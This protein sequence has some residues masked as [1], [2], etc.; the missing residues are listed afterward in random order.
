MLAMRMVGHFAPSAK[1]TAAKPKTNFGSSTYKTLIRAVKLTVIIMLFGLLQVSARTSAQTRISLKLRGATL[2]KVFAEIEKRSGYTVFYNTEVLQAAGT[3]LVSIDIKDATIDDVMHQCL[4]GLPL[5]FTV[6]DKTIFVKKEA[7]RVAIETVSGPGSP[8]PST[9][10]GIVR[11][12][13]GA[14]LAGASVYVL[15]LKKSL[16]TNKDGEF[17]LKDIPDGE[18]EV[19]ISYIGYENYRTKVSV[20]NHEAWLSAD[21]KQS[22]SKLDETVVKGY[23]STTNRLNTGDVTT[24]KGEDIEKQPISDPIL[25]LEGRVSGL[26]IVQTSGIAGAYSAITIR[27]QNSIANGNDPLYIVDGVPFNSVTLTSSFYG[28]G[29]LGTPNGVSNVTGG[30]SAIGKGMS[31][32]NSLNPSDIESIEVLKDADAT[33]IYG[34]RGANGVILITTKKGKAGSTRFDANVFTGDGKVTRMMHLLN[35]QQYMSMM[36]EAYNNDGL[37]FPNIQ[38]NPYDYNFDIDGVW[39]TT[40]YTNWQKILIGGTAHFTNAQAS[41]S[42]GSGNTQFVLGGGYS[43]QGVVYPGSYADQKAAAHV[44]LTHASNNRKFHVQFSGSYVNDN[45][46]LPQ[47][48]FTSQ[49][50]YAPDAP[51]LYDSKGN[52]NWAMYNGAGTFSNPLAQTLQSAKATTDNLI[53][54]LNVGYQILPGLELRSSFGYNHEQMNQSI[55]SPASAYSPPYNTNSAFRSN[56]VA[57]TDIKTWIIEPQINYQKKLAEGTLRVLIGSTFQENKTYSIAYGANTFASDALIT[58][59]A[60]GSVQ[61]V[62]GVSNV[63]YRYNAA[64]GRVSYDWREKYLINITAR[65]DGSSNFGPGKQFGN[66]GAIGAG[67]I[68]SKERFMED[69]LPFISFGKLRGSYGTTGNDQVPSYQFLSTYSVNASSYEGINTLTPTQLTNTNFAWEVVKKIEGGLD[70]GFCGDRVL[71]S[72]AY[73]RNRTGNQLVGYPLPYIS[74]FS[75]VQYN[76][77]AVVQNSGLEF[78]L[79]TVNVKTKD[80]SWLMSG[81]LSIPRNK[82]VAYPGIASSPYKYRY[83][84]EKSLFIKEV[85]HYTMV[86]PQTGLYT[87]ATKNANG[88]PTSPQD[89]VASQP[90]TQS[91]YGG[92]ENSFTYKGIR[93]DFLFQFVKQVGYTYE[94]YFYP[95]GSFNTNEPTGVLSRWQSTGDITGVQRFGTTNTTNNRYKWF[96]GSDEVIKDASFIRLK[97]VALSYDFPAKWKSKCHL[98][99]ARI[100][101]QCQNLLTITKYQGMD[102][103]T[104][105]LNL[106]PLKMI[107]G[108]IQLGL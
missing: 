24:V 86:N 99:D 8:I 42:G 59:V 21:L 85:Y 64:Y 29:A 15:K 104:G 12:E 93:L 65:R 82:L 77:P 52:L 103:E 76:L 74:G 91:L 58:D 54:N 30:N 3:N 107:T 51:A 33:A 68:F 79:N 35:T 94:N 95:P 69:N 98:I 17:T 48:D 84:I 73:Y 80:F 14:P 37:S 88:Q 43:N 38:T 44:N 31:P 36:H 96:Q 34:S 89:L 102:P 81:N 49:I 83:I 41:V 18:Y 90:V 53:S 46:N 1:A 108:G 22:M 23:Y 97:N 20:S 71:A 60:A 9:F 87:F 61:F 62:T 50:N 13:V 26:N 45:S 27:G 25:G 7:R 106:P 39:D 32:F 28:G 47:L 66:F 57:T 72:F 70:L 78:T 67:W 56:E 101:V 75:K 16:E 105:G 40:K 2:E 6:Q 55:L 92:L 5:E 100:Y 11:N 63:L 19:V 4:K 10:S